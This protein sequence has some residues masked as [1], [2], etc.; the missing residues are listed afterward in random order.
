MYASGLFAPVKE[1]IN[2]LHHKGGDCTPKWPPTRNFINGS[3]IDNSPQTVRW[4]V[5]AACCL[6]LGLLLVQKGLD[7]LSTELKKVRV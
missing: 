7:P 2:P 5:Q 4:A 3:Q 6:E 1:R